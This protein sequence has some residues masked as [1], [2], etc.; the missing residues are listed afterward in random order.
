MK[1]NAFFLEAKARLRERLNEIQES[2]DDRLGLDTEFAQESLGELSNYDN[3]PGDQG[4]ELYER[5]KDLALEQHADREQ[6]RIRKALQAINNGTYGIC[7]VCG[8]DIPLERLK[9]EPAALQCVDHV[10]QENDPDGRPAEESRLLPGKGGFTDT[11][12]AG[13]ENGRFDAEESWELAAAYGT[14]DTPSDTYHPSEVYEG[15]F[16][17]GEKSSGREE[18]FEGYTMLDDDGNPINFDR[19]VDY[20]EY[21][22]RR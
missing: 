15:M 1:T 19:D 2:T 9:A 4:T 20:S 12:Q 16:G 14:S 17:D 10:Y 11:P 21:F 5:E 8:K 22:L 18:V 3:H 6:E 13:V 7:E